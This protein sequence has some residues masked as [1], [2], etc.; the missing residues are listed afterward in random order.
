MKESTLKIGG[1][2]LLT[3]ALAT[4]TACTISAWDYITKG[5]TTPYGEV[6][7]AEAVDKANAENQGTIDE[8]E[9]AL[10]ASENNVL[11]LKDLNS[12]L[13]TGYSKATMYNQDGQSVSGNSV[14]P[15]KITAP[16][17][18]LLNDMGYGA[19][20]PRYAV[21]YKNLETGKLTATQVNGHNA[22]ILNGYNYELFPNWSC[23]NVLNSDGSVKFSVY[24]PSGVNINDLTLYIATSADGVVLNNFNVLANIP[25]GATFTVKTYSESGDLMSTENNL[26][27]ENIHL[28]DFKAE[29][30]IER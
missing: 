17:N 13:L 30:I 3:L 21:V 10:T 24:A 12:D 26:S 1:A 19:V 4:T 28:S 23:L 6:Q 7:L 14:L 27:I 9:E 5:D 25:T 20:H 22:V 2:C 18:D 8:L 11:R 15:Y 16:I 29:L